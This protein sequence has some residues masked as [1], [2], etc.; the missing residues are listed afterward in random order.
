[1]NPVTLAAEFARP[2]VTFKAES[3]NRRPLEQPRVGRPMRRVTR[4]AAVDA[5]GRMFKGKR[6]SLVDVALE[7][8]SFVAQSRFQH[9]WTLPCRPSRSGRAMRIVAIR[10]L[11]HAFIDAMLD[12]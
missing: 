1:L 10:A 12:R 5:H 7:A 8:R 4:R 9:S 3:E 6:T 11:H 2:G